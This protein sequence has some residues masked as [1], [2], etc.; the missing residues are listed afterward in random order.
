MKINSR[1]R[2]SRAW[3][4]VAI[5]SLALAF[6]VQGQQLISTKVHGKATLHDD[7]TRT[8]SVKDVNK[9]EMS[10]TTY[11][12]RGVAI[13]KKTFLLNENGDAIQ[14]VIYDGAGNLLARVQ[15]YFDELGRVVEERCVN[16]HNQIFRRVIRQ[17]DTNGKALPLKA[18]DY[19]VNA[20]SLRPATIDFTRSSLEAPNGVEVPPSATANAPVAATPAT[21]KVMTVSPRT[22]ARAESQTTEKKK[23][24]WFGFGKKE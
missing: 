21:P 19:A 15:F 18:F 13:C 24:G 8:E 17:Y 4:S 2:S 23:K 11:D 22:G 10:D 5:W 16:N 14:G 12:A 20:P 9:R 6:F 1:L 3:A 7:G